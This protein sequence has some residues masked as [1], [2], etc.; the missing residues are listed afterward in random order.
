MQAGFFASGTVRFCQRFQWSGCWALS[1]LQRDGVQR[2]CRC[3]ISSICRSKEENYDVQ[4]FAQIVCCRRV[5][6]LRFA[7]LIWYLYSLVFRRRNSWTSSFS[8]VKDSPFALGTHGVFSKLARIKSSKPETEAKCKYIVRVWVSVVRYQS[9]D[10]T[11]ISGP[12]TQQHYG[13]EVHHIQRIGR[14]LQCRWF[15]RQGARQ[16]RRANR[17]AH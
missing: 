10:W 3:N 16:A 6:I 13:V 4:S 14:Y 1:A 8:M 9:I 15:E 2:S 7:S 11:I 17:R 5:V 12:V